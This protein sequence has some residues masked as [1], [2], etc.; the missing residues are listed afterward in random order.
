MKNIFFF[1]FSPV[2]IFWFVLL[3]NETKQESKIP[4][5]L[6][7]KM[8]FEL[9]HN[10]L[11]TIELPTR[12]IPIED[13]IIRKNALNIICWIPNK[14]SMSYIDQLYF[15]CLKYMIKHREVNENFDKL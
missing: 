12:Q 5:Q 15:K 4:N 7:M 2:I 3:L 10:G 1:F 13:E 8:R 14:G 6:F 9:G 11:S